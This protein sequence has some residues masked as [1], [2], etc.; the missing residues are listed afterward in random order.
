MT[1]APFPSIEVYVLVKLHILFLMLWKYNFVDL[2]AAIEIHVL[3]QNDT[4]VSMYFWVD[5]SVVDQNNA[6]HRPYSW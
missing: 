6:P 3:T 5:L 2:V 1:E 4:N